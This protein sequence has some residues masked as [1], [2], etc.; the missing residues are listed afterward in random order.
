MQRSAARAAAAAL[1]PSSALEQGANQMAAVDAEATTAEA[2]RNEN[3]D[4]PK[5][6]A[7][8]GGFTTSSVFQH[9]QMRNDASARALISLMSSC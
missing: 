3:I 7:K 4:A 8:A 9:Q 1:V 5:P 2:N 6:P